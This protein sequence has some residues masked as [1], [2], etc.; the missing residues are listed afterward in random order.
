MAG[1]IDIEKT[2]KTAEQVFGF[3][4]GMM[5]S[6]MI[7]LGDRLGFYRAMSGA[8]AMNSDE[9]ARKTG[10]N[11]RWVRE[12]L[13]QQATAGLI[14]YKGNGQFALSAENAMVLADENSPFFLAGGFCAIPQQMG[15]LNLLPESFKTGKGLSYDQM[16]PE[17]NLGVER[18]L[19]PWFRTQLVPSAL[20]KL[21][22]V[23]AKLQAGA[24]VADVGCGAGIA[25]VEMAKAFPRSQ[26]HG[27]DIAK[28]PLARAV[29]HAKGQGLKNVTFHDASVDPLPTDESCDFITTFDCLHDMTRPDIVMKAIRKA[30]KPDGTWLIADVHGQPTFEGNLKDNPIAPVMYGF[31]VVCCM[32]SA[33]S[34]PDGLGLGTLGFP[35]PVARKMT[36]EAGFTRFTTKDFENPINAYYEVRP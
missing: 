25:I 5:A 12:W 2:R 26:F 35:E 20:P 21:D 19:A 4:G 27:Y 14:E 15:L 1:S 32:S 28:I 23:V 11:E 7:Y 29:E 24:K 6:A 17:V 22:G 3:L 9:L 16:G 18:L 34:Q 31:S 36:G 30:I 33:L 8:G 10:L 13:Y